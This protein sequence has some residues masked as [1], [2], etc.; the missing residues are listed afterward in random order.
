MKKLRHDI[1][2]KRMKDRLENIELKDWQRRVYAILSSNEVHPRRV[3]WIWD[4]TGNKGKSF[5]A[6]YCS[7]TLDCII[8]ENGKS[9]DL[10]YAY[11][12]QRVVIF[13]FS[14]MQ[15]EQ[16]NYQCME[17]IKNGR[18]FSSKYESKMKIFDPPHVICFANFEPK[19]ESMSADRWAIVDLVAPVLSGYLQ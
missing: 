10:K 8:F 1:S 18:V 5:L 15:E 13:D 7:T 17:S 11:N 14:R 16:V 12:G 6:T 19:R 4:K 3:Y 2:V 9:A